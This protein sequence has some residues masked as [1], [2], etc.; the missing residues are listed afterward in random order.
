MEC[1]FWTFD[2]GSKGEDINHLIYDYSLFND[3]ESL[4]E[5]LENECTSI[6][7]NLP[8]FSLID[9]DELPDAPDTFD[10]CEIAIFPNLTNLSNSFSKIMNNCSFVQVDMGHLKT[11]KECI[12]ACKRCKNRSLL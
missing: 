2:N 4:E 6:D 5:E 8:N 9:L 1:G 10:H 3:E 11:K 12:S 7:D